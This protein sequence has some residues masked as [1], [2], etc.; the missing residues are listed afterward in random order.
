M[1]GFKSYSTRKRWYANAAQVDLAILKRSMRTKSGTTPFKYFDGPTM[2]SYQVPPRS[3]EAVFCR[4]NPTPE[5]C[6]CGYHFD[7]ENWNVPASSLEVK[8]SNVGENAGRGVFAKVD[9]P[10]NA[11]VSLEKNVQSVMFMPSTVA[12]IEALEKEPVGDELEAL[13]YYMA[14]Y[15]F[16]SRK[17]VRYLVLDTWVVLLR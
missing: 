17:F 13:T 15:G 9:I 14:G 16:A 2:V 7:P 6:L 10:E 11:Y 12:L 8:K 3:M 5:E 1:L 4:R